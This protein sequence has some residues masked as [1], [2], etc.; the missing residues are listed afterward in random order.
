MYQFTECTVDK[1]MTRSVMTVTRQATVYELGK[2]FEKHDFNSFPVVEDGIALGIVTKFDFLKTFAL[3]NGSDAAALWR[4]DA[5]SGC[6]NNDGSSGSRR[7]GSAINPSFA[8]DGEP[9]D[10][11]FSRYRA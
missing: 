3:H 7:T 11:Q 6:G 8:T 5:T 9:E 1:Y 4:V 10:P 2:L